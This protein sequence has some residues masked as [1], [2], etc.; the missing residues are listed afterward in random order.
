MKT[1]FWNVDT[2]YD[3]MRDDEAYKGRLAIPGAKAIE[4][5]LEKLT[6]IAKQL[7]I[8]VI[9]TADWH[10]IES[11]ELST[12]PDFTKTFPQHCMQDT[13]GAQFVPATNPENPYLIDWKQEQFDKE[14][15]LQTRN[16]ILYKDKFD[17]FT[18]TPHSDKVVE[19]IRPEKVVVYGVATNVCVD[20][21]V[22]GLLERKVQVY[23]PTD[24][25]KEL[26]NLPLPYEN[27]QRKGA[28]LTRTDD[29]YKIL[30]ERR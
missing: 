6:A 5:N 23:V 24:A 10:T 4:G 15:V 14:K 17:I 1:I 11:E 9:N 25:I 7:G 26:P 8:K 18:A 30:G 27:W 13:K 2:Q 20:C 3:F 29:I 12:N 21:A 28:I 22:K 19:L 16:I